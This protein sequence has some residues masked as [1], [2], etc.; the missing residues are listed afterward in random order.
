MQEHIFDCIGDFESHLS[1]QANRTRRILAIITS[2]RASEQL[3]TKREFLLP[4][5][6]VQCFNVLHNAS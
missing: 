4:P 1:L 5:V 6:L 2:I 3:A